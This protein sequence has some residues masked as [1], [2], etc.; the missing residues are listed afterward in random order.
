MSDYKYSPD[1][2]LDDS[3]QAAL[4]SERNRLALDLEERLAKLNDQAKIFIPLIA[5]CVIVA[6]PI[7]SKSLVRFLKL[8]MSP[9]VLLPL[10]FCII[11]LVLAWRGILKARTRIRDCERSAA[12][13]AELI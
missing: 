8:L 1:S 13:P 9:F 3:A 12:K 10:G 5:L 2:Y 4:R 6:M 7:W 11:H